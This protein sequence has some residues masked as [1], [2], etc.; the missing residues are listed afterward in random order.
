MTVTKW[1]VG[2]F[3]DARPGAVR[4]SE[5]CVLQYSLI[6]AATVSVRRG[7]LRHNGA[8][9]YSADR[10]IAGQRL[11]RGVRRAASPGSVGVLHQDRNSPV[12]PG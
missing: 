4:L 5:W 9:G 8:L 6:R 12:D 2:G 3:G 7:G 10:T 1:T 11:A